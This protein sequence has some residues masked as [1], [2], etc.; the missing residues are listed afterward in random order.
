MAYEYSE[1]LAQA[2][3]WASDAVAQGY[4]KQSVTQGLFTLDQRSPEQLFATDNSDSRPLIVAFIGGTGVGKSS[5]LNRLA[6]QAIA[7]AGVER[8][9][10][11]EVTLYH[12]QSLH[13]QQ[14]PGSLPLQKTRISQH[15]NPQNAHIVWIDMP[16]FDSVEQANKALVFEWLP[17]IDVLIYVVSPERYRDSKAWQLLQA[18]GG[19]HAWLFVMNQWDRA[20]TAQLED[21]KQQLN[22]AGFS[23]PMVFYSSCIEPDTD[24]FSEL[25]AQLDALSSEQAMRQ[26]TQHNKRMRIQAL[27][28]ILQ[29]LLQ[30]LHR[31]DFNSFRE[32]SAC[33]WFSAEATFQQGL[34][35]NLKA[36]AETLANCTTAGEEN[37]LWDAWA[38]SRLRDVLEELLQ[39]AYQARIAIMPL[40]AR[41]EQISQW[42]NKNASMQIELAG[43]TGLLNPGNGLQRFLMRLAAICETLL[44]IV[45]MG[46]V[47]YQVFIGYYQSTHESIAY[48]GMDFAVHS[49]L[50]I[51][52]SWLIPFFLHKKLQP[53]LQKAALNGLNKGLRQVLLQIQLQIEQSVIDVECG[54]QAC[55]NHLVEII[56]HAGQE[57]DL[58]LIN[59]PLLKRVLVDK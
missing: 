21:F 20:V 45:A 13:L 18:E 10:S 48:L 39:Q 5:L 56:K 27:T 25:L 34:A 14:L 22:K 52:L 42:S 29:E 2:Q 16:D 38:Q 15:N 33:I 49:I 31:Q 32:Q 19:K 57:N 4:L 54:N 36:H 11:R 55:V 6:G 17:H 26:M 7:K 40:R 47:A 1:I 28:N 24:Q 8:P 43:R 12:H 59:E 58:G 46:I 9:T 37:T 30:D 53:S 41:L 35:W 50:L 3:D 51:G 44:P 23:E